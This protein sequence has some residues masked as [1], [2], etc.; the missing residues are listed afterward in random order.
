M[1]DV[2]TREVILNEDS[3]AVT[4]PTKAII[5]TLYEEYYERIV[6]YIFVRIN[7]QNEAENLGG[8]VFLQSPTSAGFLPRALRTDA[9]LALQDC[10]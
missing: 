3:T 2:R 1:L 9:S 5:G 10:P 4:K 7:D 6:R 8:D